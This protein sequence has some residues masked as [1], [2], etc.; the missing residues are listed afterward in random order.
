MSLVMILLLF[1][2]MG[3]CWNPGSLNISPKNICL[4]AS[5]ASFS[6]S[7]E[8]LVSDLHPELLSV[9]VESRHCPKLLHTLSLIIITALQDRNFAH[10]ME[11]KTEAE[12]LLSCH[13]LTFL[14]GV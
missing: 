6:Q 9:W 5:S 10:F 3:R 14:S 11:E 1:L 12:I 4:K 13:N 7:T 8:C 2:S